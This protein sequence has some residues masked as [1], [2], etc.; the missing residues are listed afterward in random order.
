MDGLEGLN[1]FETD[2]FNTKPK[3]QKME[4]WKKYTLGAVGGLALLGGTFAL[5]RYIFP[6]AEQTG[7][8]KPTSVKILEVSEDYH[9]LAV[10]PLGYVIGINS[11]GNLTGRNVS[12][13]K[14]PFT[15]TKP[16]VK[17]RK[18]SERDLEE[19]LEVEGKELVIVEPEDAKISKFKVKRK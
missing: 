3:K 4:S 10:E 8:M 13:V 5:G 18:L 7:E 2:P 19:T 16:K 9:L 12:K 15:F 1:N 11:D 17:D 6:S 14:E